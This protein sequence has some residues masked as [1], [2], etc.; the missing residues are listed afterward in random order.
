MSSA[1]VS[2]K[3]EA[4]YPGGISVA[5]I[6]PDEEKRSTLAKALYETHWTSVRE[7]NTYPPGRDHLKR[8]L[9]MF[10]VIFIDLDG[11]PEAALRLV[12][13]ASADPGARVSVYSEKTDT[14]LALRAMQA[15]V[16]EY[17][18]LPL[19]EGALEEV[20]LRVMNSLRPE[21]YLA[22]DLME[23][24]MN[25]GS[26][27]EKLPDVE[28]SS[29]AGSSTLAEVV[30]PALNPIRYGDKLTSAQ[31]NATATVAGNFSY[32]PGAGF[33]LPMGT[34]TLW[35]TFT[36]AEPGFAPLQ[37]ANPIVVMRAT[38]VLSW[39]APSEIAT[40]TALDDSHLNAAASVSG[41]FDYSPAAGYVLP[42][43]THTISVT[44]TPAD[45]I[46]YT[47]AGATVSVTVARKKPP[48]Q[49]KVPN[50]IEYGTRLCATQLCATT[51][52]PG[53]FEYKP[54]LGALLGAGEHP[55]SVAFTPADSLTYSAAETTVS[56]RVVKARP[57]VEWKS[58]DPVIYGTALGSAQLNAT[59]TAPG[60]LV[61]SPA[62]GEILAPGAHQISVAFIPAD[63]LNYTSKSAVVSIVVSEKVSPDIAWPSPS[64]ISYGTALSATQ[65]NATAS[66]PGEFIYAPSEGHVL[67]PGRYSLTAFFTPT[68]SERFAKVQTVTE[69]VVEVSPE[70]DSIAAAAIEKTWGEP[71]DATLFTLPGPALTKATESHA[72]AT[73]K[74]RQTRVYKGAVYEKGE[75]DQWHLQKE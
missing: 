10:D 17:L 73:L 32:T 67:A 64:A 6:G 16:R 2:Q 54:A 30:W 11:D 23:S 72:A 69:L 74:P 70:T 51:S 44:F 37:V 27:N 63:A 53:T 47:T 14:A 22:E 26:G 33:Q 3:V 45:E 39:R 4:I 9:S 60:T 12:E 13:R 28:D 1:S 29:M 25:M 43:G 65:L 58:P 50:P 62:A 21:A 46:R 48:I 34:H 7:F 20:L 42:P 68:E 57:S 18:V 59:A 71:L 52:V 35:V 40:G 41:R 66:V 8:L 19:K 61:Y 5:V 38:P 56:L 31:L 36:P 24:T 75:D 15:G 49:W 55:L